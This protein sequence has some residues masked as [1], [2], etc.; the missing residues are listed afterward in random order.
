MSDTIEAAQKASEQNDRFLF[1]LVIVLLGIAI[2]TI[3]VWITK[4][5]TSQHAVLINDFRNERLAAAVALSN[6]QEQRVA[7]LKQFNQ[8]REQEHGEF[9]RCIDAS[10]R[11]IAANTNVMAENTKMLEHIAERIERC[12]AAT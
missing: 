7:S 3:V 6:L 4:Y 1:V 10:T 9:V 11:V 5:F 8:E 12:P 2:I